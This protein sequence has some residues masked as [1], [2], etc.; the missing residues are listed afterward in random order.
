MTQYAG[1][2]WLEKFLL[3]RKPEMNLSDLGRDV[4]DLL[5]ELYWGIYHLEPGALSRADWSATENIFL[6][7]S[8]RAD[9]STFD[10]DNLT[11][12]VFL[13]HHMAIRVELEPVAPKCMRVRFSR[14]QR[15]GAT[16]ERHPDLEEAIDTFRG[17][18]TFPPV[19]F[20][21]KGESITQ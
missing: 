9:W 8:H 10:F 1:A 20:H 17:A 6:V 12:L 13:A 19:Q 5:G 2:D 16:S 14:R 4:A 7:I 18:V 3:H 11:R 15:S 21:A